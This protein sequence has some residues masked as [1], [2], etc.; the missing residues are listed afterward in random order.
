MRRIKYFTMNLINEYIL[1]DAASYFHVLDQSAANFVKE[2]EWIR[3]GTVPM[4]YPQFENAFNKILYVGMNP[5]LTPDMVSLF[6][7]VY[8]DE[9]LLDL[10]YLLNLNAEDRH[11]GI[12]KLID[13]QAALKG[14]T[15]LDGVRRY[16]YFTAISNLH[17]QVFENMEIGWEHYDIISYRSTYQPH[18]T[19][20]FHD[21]SRDNSSLLNNF[22]LSSIN[23]FVDLV[24]HYGFRGIV[25]C[26]AQVSS[27]LINHK[28]LGLHDNQFGSIGNILLAKQL[29]GGGLRTSERTDLI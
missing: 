7:S 25:V 13:F 29:T 18:I 26:N 14:K 27:Y 24:E 17:K 22:F 6:S 23:R 12:Q 28:V 11:T 4:F 16:P 2:D 19:R 10:N 15:A 8:Q 20:M 3:P 21:K 5:S 1:Q 9:K